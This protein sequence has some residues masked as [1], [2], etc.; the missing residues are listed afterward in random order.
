LSEAILCKRILSRLESDSLVQGSIVYRIGFRPL[1]AATWVR[2][3]LGPPVLQAVKIVVVSSPPN[4]VA[5]FR[6][7]HGLP[8]FMIKTIAILVLAMSF[9][10]PVSAQTPNEPNEQ[11]MKE[12]KVITQFAEKNDLFMAAGRTTVNSPWFVR[13]YRFPTDHTKLIGWEEENFPTLPAAIQAA[14]QDYVK[15]P[16]GV[17][18][19][20]TK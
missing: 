1:T 15:Y 5:E 3:P 10:L 4:R 8:N 16:K 19:K 12:L 6:L 2:F 14:E 20:Y 18:H 17:I 13:L 9:A 7:L 11:I